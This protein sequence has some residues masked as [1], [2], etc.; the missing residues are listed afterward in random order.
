MITEYG[1]VITGKT[2]VGEAR[3]ARTKLMWLWLILF[4]VGIMGLISYIMVG[5]VWE[6][7][8]GHEAEWTDYLLVSA[9]V[10]PIVLIIALFARSRVKADLMKTDNIETNS[11]FFSDCIIFR[12]FNGGEQVGVIRIDY[13]NIFR[14]K[15]RGN[16]MYLTIAQGISYPVFVGALSETELNT[17]KKQLK[18]PLHE[19]AE[20]VELKQ[21]DLIN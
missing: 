12:E 19:E 14:V 8:F 3:K 18:F 13:S 11:E 17:I 16:F 5:A 10:M 1:S 6:A 2:T 4:T 21:C 20:T 9:I 15:Q 7:I